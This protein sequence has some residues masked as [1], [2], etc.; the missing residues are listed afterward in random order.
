M[1][2]NE[3]AGGSQLVRIDLDSEAEHLLRTWPPQDGYGANPFWPSA[4][5]SQA[6]VAFNEY[7]LN[8]NN[9][10]PLTV[11]DY[12]GAELFPASFTTERVGR[13]PTWVGNDV[14]MQRRTPMDASGRCSSTTSI[15]MIDLDN[16][17]ETVLVS[18]H[19]P[20]GR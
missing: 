5:K 3:N 7:N 2:F 13:D 18:G 16:N 8:T 11:A 4:D 17:A 10:T 15:A 14:V 19:N 12:S 6:R 9:C 20:D 1:G